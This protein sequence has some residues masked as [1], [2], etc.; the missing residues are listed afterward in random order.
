MQYGKR[1]N[2]IINDDHNTQK[3][4]LCIFV[5]ANPFLLEIN[6][7]IYFVCLTF[8]QRLQQTHFSFQVS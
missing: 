8:K 2:L 5:S 4:Q 7:V 6:I 3:T 1:G